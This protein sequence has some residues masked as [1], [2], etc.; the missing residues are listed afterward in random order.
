MRTYKEITKT[1]TRYDVDTVFCDVCKK[2]ISTDIIDEQEAVHILFQGGYGSVFGD[3]TVVELDICQECFKEK[4]G[5]YCN[6]S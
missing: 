3:G 2:D 6:L 1:E 5:E 4:I